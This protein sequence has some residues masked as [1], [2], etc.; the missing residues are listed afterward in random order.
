MNFNLF[1][2]NTTMHLPLLILLFVGSSLS[3]DAKWFFPKRIVTNFLHQRKFV[4]SVVP[5]SCVVID[6]TLPA[7]RNVRKLKI[8][9]SPPIRIE[10][11]TVPSMVGPRSFDLE[12]TE[13]ERSGSWGGAWLW[14]GETVTH[15]VVN[16]HTV[17]QYNPDDVVS[18]VFKGC[19][20]TSL[21]FNLSPCDNST[22]NAPQQMERELHYTNE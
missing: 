20:P 9:P 3:R 14:P 7:C 10:S 12:P 17:R 8:N 19:K 5:S 13:T 6:S 15:T 18:I 11:T 21:P 2:T 4:T 1:L 22:S 16:Y